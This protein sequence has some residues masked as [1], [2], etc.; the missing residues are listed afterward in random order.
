MNWER[1][2]QKKNEP[3]PTNLPVDYLRMVQE[4]V[5][6]ALDSGLNEIKKFHPI[7]EFQAKGVLFEDEVIVALTLSHGPQTLTATTVY[8]SADFNP[9]KSAAIA[10]I[11]ELAEK[12]AHSPLELTL[13]ACVDSITS[14]FDH[15]LD[16]KFPE[17]TE[18]LS[19][20]ALG[21][22]EEAPFDWTRF[23][24]VVP[25]IWV[26]IDKTNPALENL[27]EDF[28][29]KNDPNFDQLEVDSEEFLA[30]RLEAIKKAQ[31]SG[32]GTFGVH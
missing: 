17:R 20:A 2:K 16:P 8:A 3:N 25:P 24:R 15:Y 9:A 1:R 12:G 31:G 14:V 22:L 4:T 6:Q 7:S 5:T 28:L 21:A 18:Q 32:G 19:Q 29:R 23:E 30:E 26:R 27:A 13:A 11:S 10:A